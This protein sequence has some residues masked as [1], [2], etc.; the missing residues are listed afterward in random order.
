MKSIFQNEPNMPI[1]PIYLG[2]RGSWRGLPHG[3]LV[4]LLAALS[5]W[6]AS[7]SLGA[8]WYQSLNDGSQIQELGSAWLVST[9][10]FCLLGQLTIAFVCSKLS[11]PVSLAS[12]PKTPRPN[13]N[14][15]TGWT[16]LGIVGPLSLLLAI[17]NIV[18]TPGHAGIAFF[19]AIWLA[20]T[21]FCLAL[22]AQGAMLVRTTHPLK[23]APY[24]Q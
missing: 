13:D 4:P 16:L 6:G 11:V 19:A 3:L 24:E 14:L 1:S 15:L 21:L 12:V 18:K 7:A 20:A 17:E 2:R 22:Q 9:I 8:F 5:G 10:V 23:V